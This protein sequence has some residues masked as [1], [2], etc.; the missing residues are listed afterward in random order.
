MDAFVTAFTMPNLFRRLLGEGALSAA[1]VPTLQEELRGGGRAGAFELLSRVTSWLVVVTGGLV[2]VAMALFSQSRAI[3][4]V[5][6]KWYL[7]ADLAVLMF[8]YLAMIC[9]AAACNAALNVLDHFMEGALS[10]IWLNLAMI[11]SLGVAGL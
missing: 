1:F 8:P 2:A 4:W 11:A 6:P 5:D 9:L 10:P 3:G 7:A